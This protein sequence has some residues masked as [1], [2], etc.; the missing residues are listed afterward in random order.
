M[1]L[2]FEEKNDNN[3]SENAVA[4]NETVVQMVPADVNTELAAAEII[5]NSSEPASL[6]TVEAADPPSN[7]PEIDDAIREKAERARASKEAELERQRKFDEIFESLKPVKESNGIIDV[8]VAGRI[9]GGLRVLYKDFPMF[10]P[11]SHFSLKR[12]P[13][14]QELVD[15]VNHTLRVRIHEMQQDETNRKTVV[16]SRKSLLEDEFWSKISIGDIVEGPVSSVATFG[17]FIDLGGIE[18]LIHISRLSQLHVDDPKKL[19]KKGQ[20]LRA[21]VVEIEKEKKR[22][23]LSRKELEESPWKNIENEFAIGSVHKG[24]VRRLT[25]FG[26]YIELRAGIDGLLRT[27]EMSWTKRIKHPSEVVKVD[28]EVEVWILSSSEEKKTVSLSLKRTLPNPWQD[29]AAKYP[30]GTETKAKVAQIMT[31]G[32]VLTVG[33]EVDG[34][35]PRSK[36]TA[37]LKGKKIPYSIGEE[38]DVI[39]A[40]LNPDQESLILT[41]KVDEEALAAQRQEAAARRQHS[42]R[43]QRQESAIQQDATLGAFS[44]GDLLSEKMKQSLM[45][46]VNN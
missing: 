41:P 45:D 42:P 40:D 28:D 16:V 1:N 44:F 36:M 32:T 19:A 29:L 38:V 20:I 3:P 43:P 34:F 7:V 10:L 26:A 14:E 23:A 12:N 8:Y 24:V 4:Q 15:V 25:D 5:E 39:I 35:M 13:A 9:K 11:A 46:N 6:P 18:G 2:N 21:V 22:I 37:V 17:V 30:I 27:G 31:Q 33:E